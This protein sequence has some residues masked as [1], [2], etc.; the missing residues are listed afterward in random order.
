MNNNFKFDIGEHAIVCCPLNVFHEKECIIENRWYSE[1]SEIN[2]YHVY[3]GG[4]YL[5][6]YFWENDLEK[7]KINND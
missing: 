7:I 3:L 6:E 5:Y 1:R 2:K 4:R